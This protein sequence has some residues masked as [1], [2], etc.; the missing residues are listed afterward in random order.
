MRAI[1]ILRGDS[2]IHGTVTLVQQGDRLRV[3]VHATLPSVYDGLHGFHIHEY[4]D[5][6]AGCSSMGGHLDPVGQHHGGRH[7]AIR[8]AGDL[9][10]VACKRGRISESFTLSV[11]WH[12]LSLCYGSAHCVLGRGMVL[13]ERPDDCGEHDDGE[14]KRTGNSGKRIACGVIGLARGSKNE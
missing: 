1:C 12:R 6:S 14:S 9:G 11:S 5:S 3:T 4:G 2:D 8:H 13:H 7:S 10:N